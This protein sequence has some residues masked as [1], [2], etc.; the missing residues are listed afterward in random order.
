MNDSTSIQ[1]P[2]TTNACNYILLAILFIFFS[3]WLTIALCIITLLFL[4]R[5]N[6]T[7]TYISSLT[8]GSDGHVVKLGIGRKGLR[9][10]S[11]A[12][13]FLLSL[14]QNRLCGHRTAKN[15]YSLAYSPFPTTTD[16]SGTTV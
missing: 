9:K 8:A 11:H 13:V 12:I 5:F 10:T 15:Y 16:S 2:W 14:F 7:A 4:S 3:P 1:R 6:R